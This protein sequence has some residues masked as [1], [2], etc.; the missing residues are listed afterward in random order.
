[1]IT[2]DPLLGTGLHAIGA[3]SAALCYTPQKQVRDWSWQSYWLVQAVCC[4]LLLPIIGAWLTIPQLGAVLGEAPASAMV[5]SF[6][7]G[8][9]YGIGGTAFGLAIRHIG[10]SLTYALAVGI[11]SILGTLLPPIVRGDLGAILSRTGA[12]WVLAGVVIGTVGI[13]GCGLAGRL[14][15]VDRTAGGQ[16]SGFALAKGLPLCL[17]AGVLSA[18]YGFALEAGEPI[19]VAADRHGAGHWRGNATYIFAN[20]GAFCTTCLYCCWLHVRAGTFGELRRRP[21]GGLPVANLLWAALTGLLWYGQFFFYNLGHVRMGDF[22]FTSWAIHMIML[23]LI[24]NALGL[25]LREWRGC[26]PRTWIAIAAA[27][28]LLIT[29]VLAITWGNRLAELHT[30][31]I[32]GTP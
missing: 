20:G 8:A 7:L 23:V 17:L 28:A 19:A 30:T 21:V 2:P 9:A 14:K 16:A 22:Q 12:D 29:A 10:F 15:E 31:S 26:R 6:G 3:T 5:L 11:S 18:V 4:W 27:L 32:G 24:S 1:M 25:A 13:L